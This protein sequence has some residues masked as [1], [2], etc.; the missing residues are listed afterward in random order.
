V[1]MALARRCCGAKLGTS[2]VALIVK[3]TARHGG[4]CSCARR[5]SHPVHEH[6]GDNLYRERVR[7][8]L[9]PLGAESAF[10]YRG[11]RN[12]CCSRK[13]LAYGISPK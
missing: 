8:T 2:P 5:K 10:S 3:S 9:S 6:L 11:E 1:T 13:R 12:R 7:D 4:R